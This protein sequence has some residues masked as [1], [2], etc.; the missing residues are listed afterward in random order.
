MTD[1]DRPLSLYLSQGLV[2]RED[3]FGSCP[4]YRNGVMNVA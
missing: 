4:D 2:H 3:R 1:H